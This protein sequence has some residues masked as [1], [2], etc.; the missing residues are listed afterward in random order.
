M[1][2]N[3][4]CKFYTPS[5][6][7]SIS[8]HCFVLESDLKNL[9]SGGPVVRNRM[10]LVTQGEGTVSINHTALDF[11]MGDL[12]FLFPGEII[13]PKKTSDAVF[14]YVDFSG[15]RAENLLRRFD[16]RPDNRRFDNFGGSIPLWKESLIR[17]S[18]ETLD[19]MAESVLLHTLSC[20][21][22]EKPEMND[23]VSTMLKMIENGF[24]SHELSIVSVG[25]ELSYHPKYLSYLFKKE[26]GVGFSE[27]RNRLR[28]QKAMQLLSDTDQGLAEIAETLGYSSPY[29]FSAAFKKVTGVAPAAWRSREE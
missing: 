26:M 2:S 6:S 10:I 3:N 23:T 1:N 12:I 7:D 17:A 13:A 27:F 11:K 5:L 21:R 14:I 18:S 28:V 29:Y 9:L 16:I 22:T 19:L 25:E 20:M 4:I 24:T 15:T 8:I